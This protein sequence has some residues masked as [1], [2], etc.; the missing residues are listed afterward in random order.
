MSADIHA[1]LAGTARGDM[2]AF[3]ALYDMLSVR[4]FNYARA[5][6]RSKEAAEDVAHDVFLQIFWQAAKLANM[7]DPTAYIMVAARNRSYDQ[8]RRGRHTAASLEDVPEASAVSPAYDRLL[9]ED[10]F[11]CLPAEQRETVYLHLVCGFTQKETAK[12]M[13]VPLAT[14]KWRHGKAKVRL[15]AYLSQ[16]REESCHENI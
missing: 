16:D 10:A 5:I 3:G 1:L 6:T 14:V 4:V 7:A 13:G 9:I 11:S 12:I 2:D 8:L 15:R